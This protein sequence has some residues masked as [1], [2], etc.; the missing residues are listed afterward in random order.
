MLGTI[1][2]VVA[3]AAAVR[4]PV[5]AVQVRKVPFDMKHAFAP[6]LTALGTALVAVPLG[7][8]IGRRMDGYAARRE[9]IVRRT[10]RPLPSEPELVISDKVGPR[11]TRPPRG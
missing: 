10:A 9:E 7:I 6:R 3:V 5:K 11:P 4:H 8:W 2:K 1:L